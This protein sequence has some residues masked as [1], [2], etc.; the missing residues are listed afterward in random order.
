LLPLSASRRAHPFRADA[1]NGRPKPN[2]QNR[3]LAE[4]MKLMPQEEEKRRRHPLDMW[5]DIVQHAREARF[6]KGNPCSRD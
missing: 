4:G 1:S 6:P 3:T 5:D 2:A